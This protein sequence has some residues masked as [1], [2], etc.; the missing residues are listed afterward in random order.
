MEIE[1]IL[2]HTTRPLNNVEDKL[3]IATLFLF[4]YKMS[5]KKFAE[6]LYTGSHEEFINELQH[7]YSEHKVDFTIGLN[8]RDIRRCFITTLEKVIEKYDPDGYYKALFDG[9]EFA[10]VIDEI[11]NY[12]FDALKFKKVEKEM[13]KQ[14]TLFQKA[15]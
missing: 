5:S 2:Y 8:D 14:L 3:R 12:N 6:L 4:C 1:S 9:D 13:A 15:V 11:V 7:E 10:L